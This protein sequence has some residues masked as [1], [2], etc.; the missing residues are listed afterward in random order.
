MPSWLA[1]HVREAILEAALHDFVT[2]GNGT[3]DT[4]IARM[5]TLLFS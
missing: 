5:K 4:P 1:L 2:A 3:L